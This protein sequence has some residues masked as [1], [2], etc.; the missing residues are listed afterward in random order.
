LE[1]TAVNVAIFILP[2]AG[3]GRDRSLRLLASQ[4]NYETDSTRE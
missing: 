4:R 2:E 1:F 3:N